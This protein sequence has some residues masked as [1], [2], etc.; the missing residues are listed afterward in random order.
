MRYAYE[1]LLRLYPTCWRTAFGQEMASVFEQAAGDHQPRGFLAYAAFLRTEFSGL[2]AGA[3]VAWTDEYLLRSRRRL[4]APFVISLFAGAAIT[5]FCQ[6]CF[7]ARSGQHE[8]VWGPVRD[9]PPLT[10]DLTAPLLLAGGTLLFISLFSMAFVWNMRT[11]GIRAGRLKPIWMPG[12]AAN[13]RITRRDQAL[14]RNSGRQ[15]RE[16]HRRLR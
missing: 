16:L 13:A 2:I 12:R 1:T 3:F 11:I 9:T 15:R 8:S 6:G 5:A 7:Y 14:H 10:S 4:N